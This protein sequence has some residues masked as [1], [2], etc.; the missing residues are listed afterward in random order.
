M[1]WITI[2]IKIILGII[3]VLFWMA[4]LFPQVASEI[5]DLFWPSSRES[6]NVTSPR[7]KKI[8]SSKKEISSNYPVKRINHKEESAG[9]A[10]STKQTKIKIMKKYKLE[11]LDSYY[12]GKIFATEI[13]TDE[14]LNIIKKYSNSNYYEGNRYYEVGHSYFR[15]TPV[16]P[17]LS[18]L[19][20]IN[21]LTNDLKEG[22]V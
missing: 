9:K 7:S 14:T 18:K 15:F 11:V 5:L 19:D 17:E 2:T 20:K 1:E 3:L 10:G 6:G 22:N 8:G 21:K 12:D 16:E 4:I 13:V